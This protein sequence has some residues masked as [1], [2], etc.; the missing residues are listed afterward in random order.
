MYS[1]QKLVSQLLLFW[2]ENRILYSNIRLNSICI[3]FHQ[4][5]H[6]TSISTCTHNLKMKVIL[7]FTF[8]VLLQFQIFGG[9]KSD[10]TCTI[11]FCKKKKVMYNDVSRAISIFKGQL[12]PVHSFEE[13]K[14]LVQLL[15]F[16]SILS[17]FASQNCTPFL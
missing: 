12:E 5:H 8:L 10:S 2:L 15:E 7:I 17:F 13:Y 16:F 11:E 9:G 4:C 3:A 6:S 14:R 1:Q